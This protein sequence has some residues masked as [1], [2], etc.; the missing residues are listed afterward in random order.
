MTLVGQ[1][2]EDE[3]CS[4]VC[5]LVADM[6][7]HGNLIWTEAVM[8]ETIAQIGVHLQDASHPVSRIFFGL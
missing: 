4:Y 2:P 7:R 1:L 6:L 8:G 3:T 5:G